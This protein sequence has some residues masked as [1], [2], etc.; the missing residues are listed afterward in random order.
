MAEGVAPEVIH[1]VMV[2][3]IGPAAEEVTEID[4]V[5]VM[6]YQRVIVLRRS[7]ALVPDIAQEGGAGVVRTVPMP[8]RA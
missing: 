6:A 4:P 1:P 5:V 8:L 7:V 3:A 2:R